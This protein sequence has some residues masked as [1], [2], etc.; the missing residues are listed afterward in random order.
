MLKIKRAYEE[1]SESDGKRIYV[2]RIWPRGLSKE[3]A[4][5][6][7]WLK[8][9]APSDEL[10]KWFGHEKDKFAEFRKRYIK[11]LS[12]PGRLEQLNRI[13]AMARENN[14]TL[15]YSARDTEHNNAVVLAELVR[16]LMK[17]RITVI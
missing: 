15:V 17:E 9:I 13:A 8:D 5:I 1:K 14:V 10:H 11:E 7:E 2:D 3:E 12:T 6:D 4:A 16:K